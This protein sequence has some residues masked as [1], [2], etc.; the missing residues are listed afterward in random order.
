MKLESQ[1]VHAGDRKRQSLAS[2]PSTTPIHL[3][4]TYLYESTAQLDR[5]FGGEEQGFSY[6]RYA[7]PTNE[8][9]EELTTTIEH[10]YGSLAT[11][12]GMAALNIA[13]HAALLDRPHSILAAQSVYGTTVTMLDQVLGFFGTEV[14]YVDVFCLEALERRIADKK[15]GC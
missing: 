9:L 14:S 7:N 13:F 2:I 3:G 5:I 8:A 12:S 15:R 1:V 10:G 11:A 6:A 4:T